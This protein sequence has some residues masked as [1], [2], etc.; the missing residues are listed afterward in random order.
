M[1]MK[2]RLK[3]V[4]LAVKEE[5]EKW[6]V[7][8]LLLMLGYINLESLDPPRNRSRLHLPVITSY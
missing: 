2:N 3:S 1:R 6:A 5:L 4:W 8:G 7:F